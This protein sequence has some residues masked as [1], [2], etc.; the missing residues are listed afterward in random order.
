MYLDLD[1]KALG[2]FLLS[3]RLH[4]FLSCVVNGVAEVLPKGDTL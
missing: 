1:L 2:E 4:D 3:E